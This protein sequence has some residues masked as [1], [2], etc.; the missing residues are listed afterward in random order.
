MPSLIPDGAEV[1]PLRVPPHSVEA[2]QSILGALLIDASGWKVASDLVKEDDFYRRENRLIWSA[3]EKLMREGATVD[4]VSVFEQMDAEVSEFGGLSYLN[5]LAQSV[6]SAA[7]I[8]RYAEIVAER[9]TLR[10]L[11]AHADE[12]AALAFR[13]HAK[14]EEIVER[15]GAQLRQIVEER[16]LRSRRLPLVTLPEMVQKSE[17]RKYLIK[18][19][20][21]AES[22][23]VL[24][25]GSGSFKS[26][27]ALD[28]CLHVAHGLPWLGRRT[29]QGQVV[30]L[31]AEGSDE[32][33]QRADAWHR[34][35]RLK[36][37]APFALVPAAV[38]L[39]QDAWKVVETVQAHAM[40]PSLV[41]IDTLSQTFGGEE[42]SA[43]EMAAYMRELRRRFS[44]LWQCA[45]QVVHHSGH[46]A[47]ERPRGSS[48]IQANTD[49]LYGI[50]R[51]EKEMLATMVCSHRKSGPGFDD[52][53]FALH[54]HVLGRDED[55]DEIESLVARHLS[56]SEEFAQAVQAEAKA[57]R[58]GKNRLLVSLA[59]NGQKLEALRKAF[60]ED[61]ALDSPEARR[62]AF[63]RALKWA[64]K[65]GFI[66]VAQGTVLVLKTLS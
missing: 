8:R 48:A 45:V 57:G 21:P 56:T 53:P 58:G 35:R 52:V 28:Q 27:I 15:S 50:F 33:G 4:V 1:L 6:P 11:I 55:G 12:L 37:D 51:D 17:Q 34:A 47:T 46:S 10:R 18:G 36:P 65:T 64:E 23:G 5:A 49:Y 29:R 59:H 44:E 54:R 3:I 38:D 19:L 63:H 31:A 41:V 13:P 20:V 32:M 61:C 62:Q 42:N 39:L 2:E 40:S 43:N 9:A 14:S 25:G 7:N 16:N 26:F 22:I 60:Y 66:E 30:Y 24:F